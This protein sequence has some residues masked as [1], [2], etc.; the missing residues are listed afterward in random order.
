M[1]GLSSCF[2]TRPSKNGFD[3]L[4][5]MKLTVYWSGKSS[6]RNMGGQDE[7][8]TTTLIS[9]SMLHQPHSHHKLFMKY[10][11][12]CPSVLSTPP[13]FTVQTSERTFI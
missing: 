2:R 4:Y 5:L 7:F 9:P 11:K 13:L 6:V 12:S 10:E 3:D 1:S 8:A